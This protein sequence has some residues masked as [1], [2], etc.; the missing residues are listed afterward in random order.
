MHRT[1]ALVAGLALA[2]A[3]AAPATA[4]TSSSTVAETL[5][6]AASISATVPATVTY[7]PV[8]GQP[9]VFGA[10][11]A[12]TSI[13]TNNPAG[14]G[15]MIAATPLTGPVTIPVG[16]RAIEQPTVSAGITGT[17]TAYGYDPAAWAAGTELAHAFAPVTNGTVTAPLR[18]RNISVPGAYT[19]SLTIVFSTL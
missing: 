5:T 15:I 2:L 1:R 3:L 19:G 11:L 4:S 9:G 6:V 8:T 16:D 7:Q 12:M 18:V 13:T 17:A 14:F 10:S